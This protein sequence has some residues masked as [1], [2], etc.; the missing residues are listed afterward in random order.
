MALILRRKGKLFLSYRH[1]GGYGSYVLWHFSRILLIS[2]TEISEVFG[3]VIL[4][5]G[6]EGLKNE[7]P[8]RLKTLPAAAAAPFYWRFFGSRFD[9]VSIHEGRML[10]LCLIRKKTLK[11][12]WVRVGLTSSPP[13]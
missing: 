11:T 5:L 12:S 6:S 9:P 3:L 7:L 4:T 2:P 8:E 13:K 10:L 1:N